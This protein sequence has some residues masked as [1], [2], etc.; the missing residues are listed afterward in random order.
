[1]KKQETS[2]KPVIH[3]FDTIIVGSGAAGLNAAVS[4][5]KSGR[6]SMAVVTEGLMLGTSR[7]TGS[8]KQTYYKM[9]LA[10]EAGDSVRKMAQTLFDGGAVDGDTALAE[11][12]NS[13][14]CFFHLAEIGVPFPQNEYGEYVGYKTDHDPLNRGSSAGPLT[15]KFM[16][17]ALI[18]EC[19]QL[20]VDIYE[21]YQAVRLL[22]DEKKTRA[23]GILALDHNPPE[24]KPGPENKP[25]NKP[26]NESA[27]V[28]FFANNVIF[29]TGG[30][31]GLY[32]TSVYPP[33]Q[34]GSMGILLQEGVPAKNLTESQFGIASIK[35]R[36]NLSGSYQQVLPRYVSTDPDG[37]DPR[38]F[39]PAYFQDYAHML[40]AIFLKGY[41]WPFDPRKLADQGSSIVD[42]AV[43]YETAVLGRRVF[44]DYLHNPI[45]QEETFSLSDLPPVIREYFE[46][47]SCM[48]D[49]PIE[50]LAAMNPDAIQLYADHGID[51]HTELLEIAVCAQHCNGGIAGNQWWESSLPHLFTV[52][53]LNGSHGVFR[54][55]G[56]ALNA[57][58]VGSR[59]AA[60]Y[61]AA[62]YP[63]TIP[64][65]DSLMQ[66][67]RGQIEETIRDGQEVLGKQPA[68]LKKEWEQIRVRMSGAAAIF[69]D[70]A[71][72]AKALEEAEKQMHFL[73]EEAGVQ[74]PD[75]LSLLCRVRSLSVS[76]YCYLSAIN[77]YIAKSG[78]S[79]GSYL[80]ADPEGIKISELLGDSFRYQLDNGQWND[81]IQEVHLQDGKCVCTWR[82]VRPMPDPDTWFE[83]V[84]RVYRRKEI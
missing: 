51:L 32:K 35:F 14:A 8:D 9:T 72:A 77:D 25:G 45:Y 41:Q 83:S 16:V 70:K 31:A 84:W 81:K 13:L 50:R 73:L 24:D 21:H 67:C 15:S 80:V 56:S 2:C 66:A 57:G 60:Q 28:I 27:L 42:I 18:R 75:E 44:L 23:C 55:G 76:Q 33:Q 20:G 62:R 68:D 78:K 58:Q 52:G 48:A 46:N 12:A 1:M 79:R 64:D 19:C 71:T 11:A 40:E 69:R 26:G 3:S 34:V 6:K 4:L 7:N 54:P 29:A 82:D 22:T 59:R 10:G 36:W 39:L 30:E 49:T 74:T 17:E 38:D 63:E 65:E 43:Y 47:S 37:G 61:I 53:E 5:A